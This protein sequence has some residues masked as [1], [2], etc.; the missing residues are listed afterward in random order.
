MGVAMPQTVLILDDEADGGFLI[1]EILRRNLADVASVRFTSPEE[2]FQYCRSA[3]PD[4]LIVDYR[5]PTMSGLDFLARVRT[6]TGYDGVPAIMVT[7][8]AVAGLKEV[9]LQQG[10][11][12]FLARPVNPVELTTRCRNL[13]NL[14]AS[15][16]RHRPARGAVVDGVIARV[17]R[18]Y[19]TL[20]QKLSTASETR[21]EETGQHMRRMAYTSR[22]VARE[23]GC[24]R[25]YCD[26]LLLSAPLHDL[27]KVGIPDRILLKKGP[28]DASE[29]EVMRTHAVIGHDLM[30]GSSSPVMQMA[31]NIAASHHEK[32]DGSGYPYGLSGD[33]IPLEAR[34]VA[35]ADVF[36]ALTN[37]RPYKKAWEAG[38][39]FAYLR[40]ERGRHF[41]PA[42]VDAVLKHIGELMDIQSR[43]ADHIEIT[44]ENIL[45][46]PVSKREPVAVGAGSGKR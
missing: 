14:R 29:W 20:F 10:V 33:R 4:L 3:E 13:L 39:A 16:T 32:Y 5:M 43:F 2:A 22:L 40:R 27:G 23:L 26:E 9:A 15:L 21:D 36:D 46:F 28:L 12:E 17:D 42:A 41:D 44:D 19:L 6:L 31:A 37:A 7:G 1:E 30:R 34:I 8:A 18:D 11:T 35:V 45:P 24:G 25:A 38:D